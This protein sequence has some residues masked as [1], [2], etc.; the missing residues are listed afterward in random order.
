MRVGV[1]VGGMGVGVLVGPYL[2]ARIFSKSTIS[3]TSSLFKS[4]DPYELSYLY[5]PS[6]VSTE[7]SQARVQFAGFTALCG[8]HSKPCVLVSLCAP[9]AV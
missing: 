8:L 4:C 9:L 1:A 3:M 5:S 7:G 6:H 2:S